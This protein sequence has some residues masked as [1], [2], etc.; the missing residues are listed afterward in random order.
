L[1]QFP[2]VVGDHGV[3]Q[4]GQGLIPDNSKK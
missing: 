2:R 1:V 3:C 4:Q